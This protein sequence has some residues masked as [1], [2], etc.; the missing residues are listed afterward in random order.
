MTLYYHVAD[1]SALYDLLLDAVMG[2]VDLSVDDTTAPVEERVRTI[3][4]ALRKAML[5]HPRIAVLAMSRSL[6][7]SPQLRPV[8]RLLQILREA[9][10]PPFEAMKAVNVIG[11]YTLGV[12]SMYASHLNAGE[13]QDERQGEYDLKPEEFPALIEV[14]QKAEEPAD[15]DADFEMGLSSLINGLVTDRIP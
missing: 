10:L 6:R 7:T 9:G 3:A 5:D 15:W 13:Y 14:M 1:K 11:Q 4:Y 8:E 12:T 2:E